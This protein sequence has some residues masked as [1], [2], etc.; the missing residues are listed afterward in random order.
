MK[1]EINEKE[2]QNPENWTLGQIYKIPDYGC[3]NVSSGP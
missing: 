1:N 3:Q 2:W